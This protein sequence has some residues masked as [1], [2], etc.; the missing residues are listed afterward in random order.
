[1]SPS[2]EVIS[3]SVAITEADLT[4]GVTEASALYRGGWIYLGLS[5]VVLAIAVATGSIVW[6]QANV[7]AFTFMVVF[8]LLLFVGPRLSAR[9]LFRAL[10]KAGDNQVLYRFDSE[11]VTIRAAGVTTTFA[12]RLLSQFREGAATLL[13]TT[14]AGSTTIIPKR[15][16]ATPDLDRV[17]ALL[18]VEVKRAPARGLAKPIKLV[19][20]WLAL[21]FAFVVVWQFMN[22]RPR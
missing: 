8:Y 9:K 5:G 4:R 17:R 6:S 1:M 16:F 21:V 19:I 3:G 22:A 13:L 18:S 11:G 7:P 12:Y 10:V 14:N 20:F 2:D 15:A